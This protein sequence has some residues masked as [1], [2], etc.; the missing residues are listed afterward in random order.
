MA[1]P[2]AIRSGQ[3]ATSMDLPSRSISRST[4]RVTPGNTVLR[5][6]RI[7]PST[8]W[9]ATAS[10]ALD[11]RLGIGIEV[12]VDRRADDHD[13]MLA[14]AD[15]G[16]IGRRRQRAVGQGPGQHLGGARLRWGILPD[17]TRSTAERLVS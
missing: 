16:G 10:M 3:K 15:C 6:M 11:H 2:S 4:I 7:C 9:S 1:R 17:R 14:A 12:L 8:S 5:R 13:Q